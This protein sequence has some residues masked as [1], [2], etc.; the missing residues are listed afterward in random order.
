MYHSGKKN[1]QSGNSH[2]VKIQPPELNLFRMLLLKL[3]RK[4]IKAD[5]QKIINKHKSLK[6]QKKLK[7][8]LRNFLKFMIKIV[9]TVI[10]SDENN[11]FEY[12]FEKYYFF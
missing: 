12:S 4:F 6:V 10:F 1:F 8:I 3:N 11:Q 7:N 2:S 5:K 9:I